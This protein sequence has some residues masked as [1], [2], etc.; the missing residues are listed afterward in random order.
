MFKREYVYVIYMCWQE[1]CWCWYRFS[2]GLKTPDCQTKAN[3]Y[4][5]KSQDYAWA[6][7]TLL[8]F[9]K[10][11]IE[12][13]ISCFVLLMFLLWKLSGIEMRRNTFVLLFYCFS[14]NCGISA[15]FLRIIANFNCIH[16]S[17]VY[18]R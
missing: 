12:T 13:F 3:R 14:G 10:Q 5:H 16:D 1:L 2:L 15:M 17:T 8:D 6:E 18:K 11:V 9:C 7:T 4:Q